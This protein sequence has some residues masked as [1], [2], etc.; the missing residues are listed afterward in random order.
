MSVIRPIGGRGATSTFLSP[1]LAVG[2]PVD[3]HGDKVE[4]TWHENHTYN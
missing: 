3:K 1:L 2:C 4:K